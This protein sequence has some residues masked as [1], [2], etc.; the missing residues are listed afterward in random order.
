MNSHDFV[1]AAICNVHRYMKHEED[2]GTAFL[3]VLE[4]E[5]EMAPCSLDMV[6]INDPNNYTGNTGIVV[7]KTGGILKNRK[8]YDYFEFL[9]L[10]DVCVSVISPFTSNFSLQHLVATY[11]P[12][13]LI[14]KLKHGFESRHLLSAREIRDH[15]AR[16]YVQHKGF[17]EIIALGD[18]ILKDLI[19]VPIC[20]YEFIDEEDQYFLEGLSY[21]DEETL[22][23]D[24]SQCPLLLT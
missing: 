11:T 6:I 22:K 9:D 19:P 17:N 20:M 12:Q 4:S 24:I 14:I 16:R 21:T 10:T 8:L 3:R 7:T 2:W 5:K 15:L 13:D 23:Y 1:Y 18:T